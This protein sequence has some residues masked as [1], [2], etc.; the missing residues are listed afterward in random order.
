MHW[1]RVEIHKKIIK[2]NISSKTE[3]N[4]QEE[5]IIII[6]PKNCRLHRRF[7]GGVGPVGRKGLK[8]CLMEP[9]L[10]LNPDKCSYTW[11]FGPCGVD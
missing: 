6:T 4:K 5:P 11:L 10:A 3:K 9:I 8:P 7:C 1:I 2:K